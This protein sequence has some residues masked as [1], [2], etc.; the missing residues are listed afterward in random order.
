MNKKTLFVAL[1]IIAGAAQA[2]RGARDTRTTKDTSTVREQKTNAVDA[3]TTKAG[4]DT[5]TSV[6]ART[7]EPTL[8]AAA[9]ENKTI[10][11][12]ENLTGKLLDMAS[13]SGDQNLEKRAAVILQVGAKLLE[14]A[15]KQTQSDFAKTV[16][17]LIRYPESR[18]AQKMAADLATTMYENRNNR[19]GL[20]AS[21]DK[22]DPER[23]KR[24]CI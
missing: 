24:D 18:E 3:A 2:N 23:Q 6:A 12:K 22:I 16:D 11:N 19:D 17:L 1:L 21:L 14:T 5:R 13:K 7:C 15:D 10:E 4:G 9:K 8:A 20:K